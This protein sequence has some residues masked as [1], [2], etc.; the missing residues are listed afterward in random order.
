MKPAFAKLLYCE[1]F[2]Q[3]HYYRPYKGNYY[4]LISADYIAK[5]KHTGEYL[6][7]HC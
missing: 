5:L 2:L 6:G 7:G 3:Y 4:P 1:T